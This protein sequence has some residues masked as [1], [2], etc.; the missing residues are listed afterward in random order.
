MTVDDFS[1]LLDAF[2][3]STGQLWRSCKNNESQSP[4]LL[5]LDDGRM[6]DRFDERK[7]SIRWLAFEKTQLQTEK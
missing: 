1:L 5:T 4:I 3:K 6:P 2:A 7:P